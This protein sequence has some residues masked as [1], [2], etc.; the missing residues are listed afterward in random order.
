M[1]LN[2]RG[3]QALITGGSK[4]IGRACAEILASEG[5][6]LHLAARDEKVLRKIKDLLESKFG[7]S[8]MIHSVDLSIGDNARDLV[9]D[10][11]EIDILVNNAGAIPQGDLWQIAELRWREA[12]DLKVFGYINLC[13]AIYPQMKSRGKGV[14]I[15]VIGAAGERPRSNYIAGGAGNAA[16]MAFTRALGARSLKDGIRLVAVNP[17]LIKTERMETLL[18]TAA[19]SRF[20]DPGRWPELI[21]KEPSPGEPKD[22]ANLVAFLASD[23]AQ[24][25]TGTVVTIDGGF[26]AA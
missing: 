25:I 9:K 14:I 7:V 6:T 19:Q 23:Y 17:G 26:A 11:P 4:G 12:W 24:Y 21:P 3:R 10:C 20:S 1:D 13:R 16:L 5:C 8:V 22:V 15:N 2:L 18:K